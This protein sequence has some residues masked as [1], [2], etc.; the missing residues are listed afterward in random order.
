[1]SEPLP[2]KTEELYALSRQKL[3]VAVGLLIGHTTLRALIFKLGLTGRQDCR[4]CR[5]EK[6]DSL[7]IFMSLSSAGMQKIQNFGLYVLNAQGSRQ[8]EDEWLNKP[9]SQYQAWDS[10]F[11]PF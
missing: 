11:T 1:M 2:N 7:H 6:E 8:H 9:I 3:K 10:A 4:L 5:D